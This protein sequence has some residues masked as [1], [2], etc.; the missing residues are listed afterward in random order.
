MT[1]RP[2]SIIAVMLFSTMIYAQSSSPASKPQAA[3]ATA[4]AG[5]SYAQ[6]PVMS[7]A[8]EERGRKLFEMFKAGQASA[9]WA[10]Y[11][12]E[13]KKNPENG[14]KF[15]AMLTQVKA[16]LGPETTVVEE[17]IIVPT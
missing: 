5:S 13:G 16:K 6:Y 2:H 9:I 4:K 17:Q 14:K 8:A 3:P 12:A 15:E 10:S 11:P 7:A 1:F